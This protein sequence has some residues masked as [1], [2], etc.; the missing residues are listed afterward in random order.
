MEI[1]N[2]VKEAPD[3]ILSKEGFY[4]T[5]LN[6][7]ACSFLPMLSKDYTKLKYFVCNIKD[8]NITKIIN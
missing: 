1:V 7:V 3:Y 6:E 5:L 4:R 8:D 2:S